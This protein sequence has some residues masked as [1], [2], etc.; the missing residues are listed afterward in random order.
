MDALV[1]PTVSADACPMMTTLPRSTNAVDITLRSK[2]AVNDITSS[3]FDGYY[4]GLVSPTATMVRGSTMNA[5][6]LA[7]LAP[8]LC[9]RIM[10]FCD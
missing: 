2:F 6:L 9:P 8:L 10:H 5:C 7:P 4:Q 1:S 3:K